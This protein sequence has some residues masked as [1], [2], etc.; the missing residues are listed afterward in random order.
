MLVVGYRN[1]TW[2]MQTVLATDKTTQRSSLKRHRYFDY[3]KRLRK[4]L[5]G[6]GKNIILSVFE[7]YCIVLMSSLPAQECLGSNSGF[8]SS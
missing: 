4:G 2:E 7:Q 1:P 5:H 3:G 6:K 8:K